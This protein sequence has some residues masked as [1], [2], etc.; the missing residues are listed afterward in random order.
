MLSYQ[1]IFHA[2]NLADVQ[3]HA[4]LAWMLA[5]LT[6]KDKPISYIERIRGARFMTLP[7]CGAKTGEAEGYRKR[8][9]PS[10]IGVG[11]SLF[12]RV[13]QGAR[14]IWVAPLPGS[15]WIARELLRETDHTFGRTAPARSQRLRD[16]MGKRPKCH[17][18]DGYQLAQSLCP[19]TPAWTVLID[20]IVN[21]P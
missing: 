20:P 10:G 8:A 7:R 16:A 14:C 19:P 5:Y 1:H 21:R 18:Q 12:A 17:Q 6:V 3:K 13:E 11:S 4:A 15:P 9:D 2:G